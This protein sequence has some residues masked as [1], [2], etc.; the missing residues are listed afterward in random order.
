AV[1]VHAS[2]LPKYRGGAPIHYALINGDNQIGVTIMEMVKQMDAG[3]MIAQDSIPI[4]DEDNVGTL[5]DKIAI[6]GCDL[7][8]KV[9]PDYVAGNIQVKA[10]DESQATFSPNIAPEEEII[11]W[12]KSARQIF[13]QVRGMNP[14]PVTHTT[15]NKE[16]LKIYQ[17]KEVEGL[18]QAG[19]VLEKTKKSLIIGTGNGAIELLV[20]QPAGK[21]QMDI[22]SFLNGLGQKIKVGDSLGK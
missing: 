13:N 8:L 12:N 18:G 4:L 5:F 14:W 2:L 6:L 10:Q 20:V 9:L 19:Q 3:A 7:L 11:D 1:N 17:V 22:V 21:P 16:R 15:W